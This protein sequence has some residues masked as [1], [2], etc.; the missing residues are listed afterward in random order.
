MSLTTDRND[1]ELGYGSDEGKVPQNKKYLVLSEEEIAK[2]YVRPVRTKY[3]HVGEKIEYDKI[4]DIN[5]LPEDEQNLGYY[6]YIAYK[7]SEYP[8][9]GRGVSRQYYKD[10]INKKSHTGGCGVETRMN[11]TIA[12]TYAAKPTFYGATY[13]VG[14][15]KHLPV[16]EFVWSD[17]ETSQVGS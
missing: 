14:C 2:G 11:E 9:V 3:I 16:A 13:C 12:R 10:Y 15:S 4:V 8:L 5:I 6:A 1:P 17:D 7:D